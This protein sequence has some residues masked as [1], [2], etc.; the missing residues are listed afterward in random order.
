[1]NSS[2]PMF[3]WG[4]IRTKLSRDKKE[5][6]TSANQTREP[7]S[8]TINVD[9]EQR[10]SLSGN[11]GKILAPAGIGAAHGSR[12]TIADFRLTDATVSGERV[13]RSYCDKE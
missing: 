12:V 5:T 11:Y 9:G 2:L 8:M 13:G 3:F 6:G 4:R 1:M 7:A 10:A